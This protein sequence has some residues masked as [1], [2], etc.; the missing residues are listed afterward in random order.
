MKFNRVWLVVILVVSHLCAL[1]QDAGLR[2]GNWLKRSLDAYNRIQITG[3]VNTEDLVE[4]TALLNFISG[5]LAVHQRNSLIAA[6]VYSGK[7]DMLRRCVESGKKDSAC[8]A[9]YAE[10]RLIGVFAPLATMP[11]AV[12]NAQL[13]AAVKKYV[14]NNPE[15]WSQDAGQIVTTALVESFTK[16]P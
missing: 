7:N 5:V 15:K 14:D 6:V 8:D 10:F 16:K 9:L 2:D 4:A 13:V 12:T 1:A 3:N 11:A